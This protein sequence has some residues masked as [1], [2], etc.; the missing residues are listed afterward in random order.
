MHKKVLSTLFR[1][2]R[3]LDVGSAYFKQKGGMK[4]GVLNSFS[5][6]IF[7][8]YPGTHKHAGFSQPTSHVCE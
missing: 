1:P 4:L 6:P 7:W 3:E 5:V 2:L 8:A